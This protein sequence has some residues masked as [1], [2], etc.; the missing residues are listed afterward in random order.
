MGQTLEKVARLT[1]VKHQMLNLDKSEVCRLIWLDLPFF[2]V[3][4]PDHDIILSVTKPGKHFP[5]MLPTYFLH[6]FCC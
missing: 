3:L 2:S 4:L 5:W 1:V 6:H